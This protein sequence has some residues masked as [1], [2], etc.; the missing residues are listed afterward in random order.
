[1]PPPDLP[2]GNLLTESLFGV[3]DLHGNRHHLTLPG[4][5]ARLADPAA[6]TIGFTALQA[7]QS[8]AWHAFLVQLAAM[9]L[10][11]AG[12]T[13]P[14]TDAA[15]WGDRLRE[16]GSGEEAWT[17][18]VEDLSKP[19][20]M[21]PPVPE[22][23]L[24]GFNV[25]DSFSSECDLPQTAR[26]HDYKVKNNPGD[27]A[28]WI[29]GLISVQTCQ[30]Y[31]GATKYGIIRMNGG[32]G[33]RLATGVTVGLDVGNHFRKDVH[34][35]LEAR[36]DIYEAAGFAP[37]HGI[38]L[39]WQE[40]WDGKSGLPVSTL[41]P[42]VIEICRRLRLMPRKNGMLLHAIGS[43]TERI[44]IPRD[45]KQW[46]IRN[47]HGDPWTPVEKADSKAVSMTE[48][49]FTYSATVKI[50]LSSDVTRPPSRFL[51]AG[52]SGDARW[53]GK[54]LVK[55][56]QGKIGAWHEREVPIPGH[57][58]SRF[59]RPEGRDALAIVAKDMI[60]LAATMRL[61][62][63]KS[64]LTALWEDAEGRIDQALARL[65]QAVDACFFDHL[66]AHPDDPTPWRTVLADLARQILD[67]DC[68]LVGPA[69]DRWQR[70]S[71]AESRFTWHLHHNPKHG[72][73]LPR[74]THA[75]P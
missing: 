54:V 49:G 27:A 38:C 21:Q 4:V 45:K 68:A 66:W 28:H 8:H 24:Q 11:R 30:N 59:A 25:A 51:A 29:Y 33:S 37:D 2:P 15:W 16:L 62:I 53:Y 22:L 7:H 52:E 67:E 12:V 44:I 55:G 41:D 48:R 73:F 70:L 50:L 14:P 61:K 60:D 17:L 23:N 69:A 39:L 57:L 20:F 42:F 75:T 35:I 46:R 31:S 63:L 6:T 5:L 26:N 13:D 58:R 40:S 43:E 56:G 10:H 65:E 36:P 34:A 32:T 1:M 3:V 9:V 64:A 74:I 71:A 19:A 18:V 72:P 47:A